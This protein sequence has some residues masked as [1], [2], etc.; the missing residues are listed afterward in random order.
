MIYEYHNGL[1]DETNGIIFESIGP[2]VLGREKRKIE[3]SNKGL[4]IR[5]NN[6]LEKHIQEGEYSAFVRL[7][8]NSP[9]DYSAIESVVNALKDMKKGFNNSI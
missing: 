7:M 6:I 4:V 2:I 3:N 5:L 1:F 9:K 8:I